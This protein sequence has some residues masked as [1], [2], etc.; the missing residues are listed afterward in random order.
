MTQSMSLVMN[1]SAEACDDRVYHPNGDEI[2]DP[3]KNR[4]MVL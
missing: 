1:G 3:T 2:T 4:G